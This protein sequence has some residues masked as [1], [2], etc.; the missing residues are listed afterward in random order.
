MELLIYHPVLQDGKVI[1]LGL[2]GYHNFALLLH[3][4][5]QIFMGEVPVLDFDDIFLVLV[6]GGKELPFD[7][8]IVVF[9][10][11]FVEEVGLLLEDD[12]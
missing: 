6:D 3:S 1:P 11:V 4:E 7:F 12:F 9:D 2:F 10:L 5:L 8:D